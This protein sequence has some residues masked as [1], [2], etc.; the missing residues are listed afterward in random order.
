[1]Y[2]D[3]LQLAVLAVMAA[4]GQQQLKLNVGSDTSA[5]KE[6]RE[7]EIWNR[8]KGRSVR[9]GQ[10]ATSARYPQPL[11]KTWRCCRAEVRRQE[12]VP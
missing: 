4:A 8:K 1:M 2:N 10:P 11:A 7:E 12:Q 9:A 5:D 3:C 6:G